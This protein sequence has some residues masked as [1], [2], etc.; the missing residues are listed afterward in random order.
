MHVLV[1]LQLDYA[2][3]GGT[4]CDT[5]VGHR[6]D[7]WLKIGGGSVLLVNRE[8]TVISDKKISGDEILTVVR[9]AA[10]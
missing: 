1:V 6:G 2:C 3:V 7:E 8:V 4:T 5:R 10:V 9:G